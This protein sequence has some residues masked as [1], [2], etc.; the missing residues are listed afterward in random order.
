MLYIDTKYTNILG[1]RLRNFKQK[2]EYL[3]N[4][5]C[6]VCG[7][8]T[9]NKLKA[10]GYIVRNEQQLF[11]KCHNC[12]HGCN[13]GNLIKYVDA[14]LYNEYVLERYKSGASKHHDHKN[15][16]QTT[17][18][19][20]TPKEE[21]LEDDILSSLTRLDKM[22]LSH[23]AVQYLVNRKIPKEK[24]NLLYFAP[25]FKAFTNSVTAKFQE[26]IKDEHP[27]MIIPYFT[28][29]GKCFA[30]QARAYGKE[31]PKYYTIKVDETEERIYGLDRIDYGKPIYIVEGPI[32]SLFIPNCLAVSGS[33]FDMPTIR[34]I[35]PNATL[36]MD[37]EPRSKEITKLLDKNI[38]AGYNVC[39]F[40][41]HI[42]QK[43]INEMI[44]AGMTSEEII[45]TINTNTFNGIEAKLR[46]STWKK[47]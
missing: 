35:L 40:P 38:K 10:R 1:S 11:Y 4:F 9:K 46:F 22:P 5:S 17:V 41:E 25:K 42:E 34:S 2:K 15:I 19:L 12:G 16:Q 21:L 20:E 31:E 23:P 3:W 33:S 32:D 8:S 27:R 13:L 26:P 7:D 44:L 39:M 6:P 29:A 43:D 45:N 24:W 47:I 30:F 36:V 14:N 37:N 28:P 18:V